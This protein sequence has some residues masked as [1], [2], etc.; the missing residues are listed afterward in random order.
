MPN[1]DKD[2]TKVAKKGEFKTMKKDK[3]KVTILDNNELSIACYLKEHPEYNKEVVDYFKGKDIKKADKLLFD[4]AKN[5]F[6]AGKEAQRKED[7]EMKREFNLS[8]KELEELY[9]LKSDVKE[10][11]RLLKEEMNNILKVNVESANK[12][13][14][15]KKLKTKILKM[16]QG[17]IIE[18]DYRID[19]LA[20]ENL[21]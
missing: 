15:S 11:I 20:G 4:T 2:C 8:E 14:V 9:Y 10:F 5:N 13:G 17:N 3:P 7:F 12:S 1:I 18:L 21:K 19:K 6:E 16:M